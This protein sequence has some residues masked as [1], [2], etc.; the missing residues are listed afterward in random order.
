MS[1]R[2]NRDIITQN[3]DRE[4]LE[5]TANDRQEGQNVP[6]T[7]KTDIVASYH[8]DAD[9][10]HTQH[11]STD[12]T[13][14]ITNYSLYNDS[15]GLESDKKS[16][17]KSLSCGFY[18]QYF[19]GMNHHEQK[20]VPHY[21][22]GCFLFHSHDHTHEREMELQPGVRFGDPDNKNTSTHVLSISN[23]ED[24]FYVERS[25]S[26][27][28]Q[29]L[30]TRTLAICAGIIHGCAGPGGVLGVLPATQIR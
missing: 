8:N 21:G 17:K 16:D 28:Q 30:S 1:L 10:Y 12:S 18:H 29:S 5:E 22:D 2:N 9:E 4:L 27:H 25:N 11:D 19:H 26:L 15:K 23:N 20:I 13:Q 14:R 24:G 6:T 7:R 3:N